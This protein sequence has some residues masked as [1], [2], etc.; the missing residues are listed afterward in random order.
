MVDGTRNHA[1]LVATGAAAGIDGFASGGS[2]SPATPSRVLGRSPSTPE[3]GRAQT[4]QHHHRSRRPACSPRI[5]GHLGR[6]R[7]AGIVT[8]ASRPSGRASCPGPHRLRFVPRPLATPAGHPPGTGAGFVRRNG[9]WL[10]SGGRGVRVGDDSRTKSVKTSIGF[11]R[12]KQF[13][14][15]PGRPPRPIPRRAPS[16]SSRAAGHSGVGRGEGRRAR[17]ESSTPAPGPACPAGWAP[18]TRREGAPTRP[19]GPASGPGRDNR[20]RGRWVRSGKTTIDA[21]LFS[22][23]SFTFQLLPSINTAP[24]GPVP[25][26]SRAECSTKS[27][28]PMTRRRGRSLRRAGCASR[29]ALTRPTIPYPLADGTRGRPGSR[30]RRGERLKGRRRRVL[31]SPGSGGVRVP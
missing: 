18:A 9:R 23:K 30:S 17:S 29:A 13:P 10:R 27:D 20:A 15:R 26:R 25:G 8:G 6:R 28:I 11:V 3:C 2:A 16:A 12:G 24:S 21:M 14:M 4:R 31:A 19:V 22:H 1:G 7:A 5:R